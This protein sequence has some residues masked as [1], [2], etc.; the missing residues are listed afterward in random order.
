MMSENLL[1]EHKSK[2]QMIRSFIPKNNVL[3]VRTKDGSVPRGGFI[4]V[5]KAFSWLEP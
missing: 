4:S 1:Y 3:P 2:Y 5:C